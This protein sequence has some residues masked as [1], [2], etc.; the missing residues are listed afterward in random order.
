MSYLSCLFVNF[1]NSSTSPPDWLV[2][3][4]S[5]FLYELT[6]PLTK[7]GAYIILG[8]SFLEHKDCVFSNT[9]CRFKIHLFF[10]TIHS[11]SKYLLSNY[12][13]PDNVSSAENPVVYKIDMAH[14]LMEETGNKQAKKKTPESG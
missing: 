14:A 12:Y 10:S 4:T 7:F 5:A 13:V 8:S 6:I 3:L 2:M 9:L 1:L 11:F